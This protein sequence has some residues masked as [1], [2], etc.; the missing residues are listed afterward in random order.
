MIDEPDI[1]VWQPRFPALPAIEI[2]L[3]IIHHAGMIEA[4]LIA[5][6]HQIDP[7]AVVTALGIA[8]RGHFVP[9]YQHLADGVDRQRIGDFGQLEHELEIAQS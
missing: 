7:R 5:E 3:Q 9:E 8:M 2:A 6:L 1:L 4:D